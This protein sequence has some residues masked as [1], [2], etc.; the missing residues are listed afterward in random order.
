MSLCLSSHKI[1]K[2]RVGIRIR[3]WHCQLHFFKAA[4]ITFLRRK[5]HGSHFGFPFLPTELFP[6]SICFVLTRRRVQFR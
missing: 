1:D 3:T 5:R 4:I 6:F 2:P